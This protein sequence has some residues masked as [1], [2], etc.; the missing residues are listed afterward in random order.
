MNFD[1]FLHWVTLAD[2]LSLDRLFAPNSL[3]PVSP[4]YP[5][6]ELV[7]DCL[8]RLTN[9]NLF[10]AAILTV[11]VVRLVEPLLLFLLYE[12]LAG[13]SRLASI[14]TLLFFGDS[15]FF[16]FHAQYA[17]ESLAFN[18]FCGSILLFSISASL[19]HRSAGI[20][21]ALLLTIVATSITHHLTSYFL[22]IFICSFFF[23]EFFEAGYDKRRL[24]AF[25]VAAAAAIFP[26]LWAA[27]IQAPTSGYLGPVISGGIR[28]FTSMLTGR[29]HSEGFFKEL[30]GIST[31]GYLRALAAAS[32]VI[33]GVGLS[34][35]F[36]RSVALSTNTSVSKWLSAAMRRRFSR[37]V[38]SSV[39]LTLSLS[40][41]IY[42]L[43]V[44]LRLTS[45]GWEL[46]SRMG[47]FTFVAVAL[48]LAIA[49]IYY[50]EGLSSWTKNFLVPGAVVTL[51]L[52]GAVAG[53]GAKAVR[54]PYRVS[55]DALS[56]EP[57]GIAAA[58]WAAEWLGPGNRFASDR[59]NRVLL[60]T[61]GQQDIVTSLEDNL[62]VSS[63]FFNPWSAREYNL[64]RNLKVGFLL[65]DRRLSQ[66]LPVM[67]AYYEG[68]AAEPIGAPKA[69]LMLKYDN[70]PG[71]SR[72]YDNGYIVIYD[73]RDVRI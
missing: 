60:A 10:V 30:P 51:I 62:Q 67:G 44:A 54:S 40:T 31:P 6:L 65:V 8:I 63:V 47:P 71:V 1:E 21:L 45:S 27:L 32:T 66:A 58:E 57:A 15:A 18:L 19:G 56:V 53:W 72:I 49:I 55:A 73:V 50:W 34:T 35:G 3:L 69:S 2:M 43:S 5:G 14:A 16:F 26:L 33:I 42:P 25:L 70:I 7:T 13:S 59:V 41:L 48:V 68:G 36:F 9:L 38:N 20:L 61:Y 29:T 46:G 22:A 12:R 17:Y 28:D 4:L 11:G 23:A 39:L 52:G 24:N 64:L 37:P